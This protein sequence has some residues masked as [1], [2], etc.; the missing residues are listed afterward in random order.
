MIHRIELDEL[1]AEVVSN[2][3]VVCIELDVPLSVDE[4]VQV[5][6]KLGSVVPFELSKYRPNGYPVEATLIDNFGDGQTAAPRSFGEGWHQDSSFMQNAPAYTLLHAIDIPSDG[7]ETLFSDTR[8]GWSRLS[9]SQRSELRGYTLLH[10]VRDSYQLTR[11]DVGKSLGEL[12][13]S[14]PKAS[15]SLVHQHSRVGETL[16]LSPLYVESHLTQEHRAGYSVALKEVLSDQLSHHWK[17]GQILAWDNR[18]VLHCASGYAGTQRRRLIRT[19]VQDVG[20]K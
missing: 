19:M 11:R 14:L 15:H 8:L 9:D 4:F 12:L 10:A 5:S 6:N 13:H 7:G 2:F 17:P 3:G 1:C 16:F 20:E 18:V